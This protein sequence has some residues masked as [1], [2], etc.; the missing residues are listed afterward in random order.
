MGEKVAK[1]APKKESQEVKSLRKQ[2]E[3]ARK[4]ARQLRAA[5]RQMEKRQAQAKKK[6]GAQ[7][8]EEKSDEQV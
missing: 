4:G 3:E 2:Y 6:L 7:I 8:M 1:K 5:A